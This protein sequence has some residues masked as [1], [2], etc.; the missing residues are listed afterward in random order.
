MLTYGVD[1]RPSCAQLLAHPYITMYC[2]PPAPK[3][4]QGTLAH[5]VALHAYSPGAGGL[6]YGGGASTRKTREGARNTAR[7]RP[8]L[9]KK[10]L[11]AALHALCSAWGS[12]ACNSGGGGGR[13][14]PG[15][16]QYR[17]RRVA[18]SGACTCTCICI[19]TPSISCRLCT[20][21]HVPGRPSRWPRAGT[22]P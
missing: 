7:L 13:G 9:P 20:G 10:S 11:Q 4:Q 5:V 15:G 6:G 2:A 3:P 16:E 14:A 19:R 21:A 1:E 22:S 8:A 18:G 17:Q 12:A